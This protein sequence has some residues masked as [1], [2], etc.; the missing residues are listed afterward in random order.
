MLVVAVALIASG[1]SAPLDLKQGD[2]GTPVVSVVTAILISCGGILVAQRAL[3]RVGARASAV[4]SQLALCGFMVVLTHAAVLYLL[5]EAGAPHWAAFA[6]ALVAPWAA[7]M[8]VLR[9]PLA[10][11]LCGVPRL[12]RHPLDAAAGA[13]RSAGVGESARPAP[14]PALRGG[15][16]RELSLR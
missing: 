4:I 5:H 8:L 10:P 7:A 2:F 11:V 12:R 14:T 15:P 1:A 9:T 13:A 3:A 16:S 6:V